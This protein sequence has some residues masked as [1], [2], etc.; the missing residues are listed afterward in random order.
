MIPTDKDARW[1]VHE[2]KATANR[3]W[4]FCLINCVPRGDREEMCLLVCFVPGGGHYLGHYQR[5]APPTT[6]TRYELQRLG[7]RMS[8]RSFWST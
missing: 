6:P 5:P 3:Y 8:S 1:S 2:H 4:G 7:T